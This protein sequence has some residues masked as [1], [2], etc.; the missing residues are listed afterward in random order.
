MVEMM[1]KM[2]AEV[3]FPEVLPSQC[4]TSRYLEIQRN[5]D[6]GSC[7]EH[8]ILLPRVSLFRSCV[9]IWCGNSICCEPELVKRMHIY[10]EEFVQKM[11][12]RQ[13]ETEI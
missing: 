11:P 2:K 3:N 7:L 6:G 13:E 12:L 9:L 4:Q 1:L 10:L 5:L 8:R